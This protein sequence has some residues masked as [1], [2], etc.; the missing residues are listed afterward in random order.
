MC[1]GLRRRLDF[2]CKTDCALA[3]FCPVPL[4][5]APDL[6]ACLGFC[7]IWVLL[8]SALQIGGGKASV[9]RDLGHGLLTF[10]QTDL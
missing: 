6:D 8:S 7:L 1:P 3:S 10:T 4:G 2:E 9:P 5:P